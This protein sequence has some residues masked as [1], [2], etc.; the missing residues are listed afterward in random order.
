MNRYLMLLG[1]IASPLAGQSGSM[2]LRGQTDVFIVTWGMSV[3]PLLA[4]ILWQYDLDCSK[5]APLPGHTVKE[6]T[7]LAGNLTEAFRDTLNRF[8]S[9][10]IGYWQ[11]D[12]IVLDTGFAMHGTY[13]VVHK[14]LAHELMHQLLYYR[15]PLDTVSDPRTREAPD[16]VH[17][18]YPFVY[19]CDLANVYAR[20]LPFDSEP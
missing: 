10:V 15:V 1:L 13:R 5:L 19:P 2:T 18:I 6:V 8:P 4:R 20:P 9:T 3:D 17:P 11:N 14:T 16:S 12:T 7:W